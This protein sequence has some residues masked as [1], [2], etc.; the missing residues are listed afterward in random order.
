M[1]A[2]RI[3]AAIAVAYVASMF[4]RQANAVIAPELMSELSLSPEAMGAVTGAFFLAF[5][6][7]QIPT[8]VLLDRYGPRLT[9]SMMLALAVV[10]S[11]MFAVA[12]TGLELLM[13]RVLIGIGCASGLVGGLVVIGR[14]FPPRRFASLSA[15]LFV[16]GGLGNLLATTPLALATDNIGW[17]GSFVAMAAVTGLFTVML[18][19]AV[20]DAPPGSAYH[21]RKRETGREI[22]TGLREVVVHRGLWYICVIQFVNYAVLLTIIGLWGGPYL[23]DVHGLD[24]VHRGNVLMAMTVAMLAGALL[25][26]EVEK[27]LRS[28]RGAVVAAGSATAL[29][30]VVLAVA[31]NLALW[32]VT[33]LLILLGLTGSYVM[34]LHAHARA[35]LPDR[36]LGRGLT[37]QNM[38]VM[39]G[40]FAIQSA[41]GLIVGAF[42]GSASTPETAYRAVFAFLAALTIVA[43]LIYRRI[44]DVDPRSLPQAA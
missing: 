38:A 21:T 8:G 22:F 11:F 9:M 31:P 43:I 32:Q 4:F 18:F 29:I 30:L 26:G 1:A 16:I 23:A 44:E 15:W 7:A 20:R 3:Y 39:V 41:S 42:E 10:G 40:V 37:L 28:R 24:G 13:A 33:V 12:T 36:I 5:A 27:W 34:L 17:R 6:A 2:Y 35:V 19:L 25:H 14:W